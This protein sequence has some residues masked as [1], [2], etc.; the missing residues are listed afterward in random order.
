M[1]HP[2]ETQIITQNWERLYGELSPGL[3]RMTRMFRNDLSAFSPEDWEIALS[4]EFEVLENQSP[5]LAFMD[6]ASSSHLGLSVIEYW[7][8][9][10]TGD[11]MSSWIPEH[12]FPNISKL[13][14]WTQRSGIIGEDDIGEFVLIVKDFT[15]EITIVN[16]AIYVGE[17]RAGYQ[18][19]MTSGDSIDFE[20]FPDE[21]DNVLS[22][23]MNTPTASIDGRVSIGIN[24]KR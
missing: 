19:E 1:L 3:Y 22:V 7:R 14:G 9:N 11:S 24:D 10:I 6:F 15:D 2:G 23:I 4:V 12:G 8:P 17:R 16:V 20:I 18:L 13:D 5:H 21:V